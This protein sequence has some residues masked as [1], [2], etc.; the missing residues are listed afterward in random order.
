MILVTGATGMF[1]GN[2][3]EQLA[4]RGVPVRAMTSNPE[5]VEQLKRPGG[6]SGRGGYGSSRNAGRDAGG[7]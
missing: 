2:V 3:T 1:G 4:A 6:R 5:R 7:C